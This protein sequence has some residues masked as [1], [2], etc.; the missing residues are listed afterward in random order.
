MHSQSPS[1]RICGVR[2]GKSF[3]DKE[4]GE[5]YPRMPILLNSWSRP[6]GG[7]SDQFGGVGGD[8][9]AVAHTLASR[10]L[11]ADEWSA[12]RRLLYIMFT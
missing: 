6:R 8:N 9:V 3:I 10:A 4:D 7:V 12:E 1:Y 5:I 11:A 2:V